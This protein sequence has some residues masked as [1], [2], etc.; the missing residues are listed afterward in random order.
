MTKFLLNVN[1]VVWKDFKERLTKNTT[2]NEAIWGLI[3]NFTY[4]GVGDV[5]YS[6]ELNSSVN[7]QIE[8]LE[9]G[10]I[11]VGKEEKIES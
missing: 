10:G 5:Y 11:E 8:R 2:L 7:E 1:E 4:N 6:K 3:H 9:Q